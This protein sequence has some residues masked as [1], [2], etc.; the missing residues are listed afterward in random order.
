MNGTFD[1]YYFIV[2]LLVFGPLF[3]WIF[4]NFGLREIMKMPGEIRRKRLED[5]DEAERVHKEH[6][7]KRGKG[8]A[9]TGSGANKTPFGLFAQAVTY[10]WF[11][12]VIGFFASSPPYAFIA[13]DTAQIKLSLSHPG[14]RKV[15]CRRRTQKELAELPPNMRAP[16]DCPRE[17]WPVFVKIDIDDKTVMGESAKPNGLSRDGPSIFY[18]VFRITAGSHRMTLRLR[19]KGEEGFGYETTQR[20]ELAP[21]QSLAIEFNKGKGGF[22]VK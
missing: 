17:R 3:L 9:D 20:I 19:D 11:A 7:R 4:Y 13:P 5:R 10:A 2:P 1:N 6:G 15:E 18:R 8:L 16:A 21:M 12:L 22:I 14:Q